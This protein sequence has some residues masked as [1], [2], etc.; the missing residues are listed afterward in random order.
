MINKPNGGV[1][2]ARN[3]SIENAKG[4]Y[5]AFLDCDDWWNND[6]FDDT[7]AEELKNSNIDIYGFSYCATNSNCKYEKIYVSAKKQNTIEIINSV[8]IIGLAIALFCFQDPS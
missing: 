6:F 3:V 1:A 4:K 7:I 5:L 8:D 2:S